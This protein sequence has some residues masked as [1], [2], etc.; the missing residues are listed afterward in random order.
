MWISVFGLIAL[1]QGVVV[2]AQGSPVGWFGLVGALGAAVLFG[3][4]AALM[5]ISSWPSAMRWA[6]EH[7]TVYPPWRLCV[8]SLVLSF[9]L[10]GSVSLVI[11]TFVYWT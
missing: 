4:P 6:M 8:G 7:D 9:A 3:V 2:A 1:V 5:I 10:M 11:A